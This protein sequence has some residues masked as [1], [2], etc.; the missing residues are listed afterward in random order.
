MEKHAGFYLSFV[1]A[2]TK[3]LRLA[4]GN[5]LI[6]AYR[7]KL[8]GVEPDVPK[9]RRRGAFSHFRPCRASA[10]PRSQKQKSIRAAVIF[11]A[12]SFK[13]ADFCAGKA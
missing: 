7:L 12:G 5:G 10:R 1:R 9:M 2:V 4:F 6:A 11:G 3:P 8:P 13:L